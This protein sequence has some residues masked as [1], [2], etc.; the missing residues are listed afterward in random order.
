MY[1]C[2]WK[3]TVNVRSPLYV[4]SQGLSVSIRDPPDPAS[5][6]LRLQTHTRDQS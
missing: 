2:M 1:G 5:P 6:A 4:L 3:P